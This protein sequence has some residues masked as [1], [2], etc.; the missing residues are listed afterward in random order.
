MFPG[1]GG[2][3]FFEEYS[4][5][6]VFYLHLFLFSC[7]LFIVRLD[8]ITEEKLMAMRK[9]CTI[10]GVR[11]KGMFVRVEGGGGKGRE[12]RNAWL[13]IE[14]T[15]GKVRGLPESV[16]LFDWPI[17]SKKK[18]DWPNIFKHT[19]TH[20][21]NIVYDRVLYVRL[22]YVIHC[23]I[24]NDRKAAQNEFMVYLMTEKLLTM[25]LKYV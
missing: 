14:C 12:G 25:N 2:R 5:F 10:E 11:Y 16:L 17:Q 19:Q 1:V 15:E 6:L 21:E 3:N 8:Q 9:G 24:I 18:S 7:C 13:T 23:L 20:T 22:E 4:D